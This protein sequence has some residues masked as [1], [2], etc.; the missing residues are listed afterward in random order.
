MIYYNNNKIVKTY[1]NGSLINKIDKVVSGSTPQ[2]YSLPDVPFILNY[3]AKNY[4]ATTHTI[5]KTSGQTKDVDAV[6]NYGYHIVDHSADGY[7]TVTG[8]TRMV[9]SG[10]PYL[11]RTNTQTGCTMTIVSKAKTTNVN[12]S[13]SILTNRGDYST[14]NWM[15]RY[16]SNGIF[17][18]G[19][20]TYNSPKY[21]TSTTEQPITASIRISYDGSVKQLLNDWTNDGSYN[22][23]FA[24]GSGYNG[25]SSLFCDYAGIDNEFWQGDFYWVYMSQYVLTDEQ[26]QQVIDYNEHLSNT[27]T[28]TTSQSKTIFQYVTNG[29]EP[30][31][32]TPTET[33]FVA[34]YTGGT[35]YSL[36][37]NDSPL[38]TSGETHPNGYDF[39]AMT[40]V[41]IGDCV[42]SVFSD[43]FRDCKSLTSVTIPDSVTSIEAYAFMDCQSLTGVTI[44]DSVTR[45][46]HYSFERCRNMTSVEIGSGVTSIAIHAF[47]GCSGLTGIT[48]NAVTPPTLNAESAFYDTNNCPIYVP[49]QSVS[50]Y[51][52][53]SRWSTYASRIVAI[54]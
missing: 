27:P 24:Y 44:P 15:W 4:D 51:K 6:C 11:N 25:N 28:A 17:L 3:N 34:T 36:E 48:I 38:L 49:A 40:N 47:N 1:Q 7:I 54:S 33:K 8:N 31:P 13:Y 43:A 16:P 42:T 50:A 12:E 10:T 9:I 37:C 14:M 22:G 29:N 45:I 21:F 35:T 53:A 2:S 5:A 26:I 39:S 32:P 20:S 41:V 30:T 18:H 23:N 19:S 46:E 52:S